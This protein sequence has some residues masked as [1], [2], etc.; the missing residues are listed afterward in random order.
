MSVNVCFLAVLMDVLTDEE[1]ADLIETEG[2]VRVHLEEICQ[3]E[4]AEK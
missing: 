1:M 2:E 4:A 3:E